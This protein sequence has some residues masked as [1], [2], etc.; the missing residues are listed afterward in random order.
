[1]TEDEQRTPEEQAIINT[2]ADRKGEEWAEEH[3]ELI[4]V[5]ARRIGLI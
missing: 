4:L 3:A 5:Q 1:M 2:V